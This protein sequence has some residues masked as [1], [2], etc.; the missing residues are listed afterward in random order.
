MRDTMK[1]LVSVIVP[2]YKKFD[3]I[4]DTLNSIL[5]QD[6]ENIEII[7][8]DDGSLNFDNEKE[9]IVSL[10]NNRGH[11][12]TNVIINQLHQNMG[13][14]KNCNS[15]LKLANGKYVKLLPPGDEFYSDFIISKCVSAL[16]DKTDTLLIG[17]TFCKNANGENTGIY[18]DSI[19]YR[20]QARHQRK[21]I[22]CPTINDVK[23]MKKMEESKRNNILKSR[24]VISTVSVFFPMKVLRDT[25]GFL[26]DYRLLE[27]MPYWPYLAEKGIHFEFSDLIMVLY[28]VGGISNSGA[29]NSAFYN[30]Y[31]RVM[32]EIYINNDNR[33]GFLSQLNKSLRAKEIDW[34]EIKL[35]DKRLA[36]KLKFI[37]VLLIILYKKIKYLF[38]NTRL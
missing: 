30:E 13:T 36:T 35:H 25:G 34:M 1:D 22:I 21:S 15:A 28:S 23:N 32:N 11:N 8:S 27:D 2:C 24:C 3:G 6:Y 7:I 17:R 12:I 10:L 5:R 37:D 38:F 14:V 4:E 29:K 19:H 9:K 20:Y 26:E 33:F 18:K 16:K 31:K